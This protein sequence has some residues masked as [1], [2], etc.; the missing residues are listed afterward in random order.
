MNKRLFE[1]F[2]QVRLPR[3]NN[4]SPE[5]LVPLC[6]HPFENFTLSRTTI[7]K[8]KP[9]IDEIV[10]FFRMA[11]KVRI[12]PKLIDFGEVDELER[13]QE[14]AK[15]IQIQNVHTSSIKGSGLK[16]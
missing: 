2:V 14:F 3:N 6:Q 16:M 15:E 10:S 9:K 12:S 7:L 8:V 13:K 11:Q 5:Y 1:L 4:G